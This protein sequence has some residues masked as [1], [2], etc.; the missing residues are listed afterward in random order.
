MKI[1]SSTFLKLL[2][3][4][5]KFPHYFIGSNADLPIV[6]GSILSHDHFQGGNYVFPMAKAPI[7]KEFTIPGFDG[8]AAG[9]INWPLSVIRLRSKEYS[10]LTGAATMILEKWRGYT[11]DKVGILSE[12]GGEKHNS[13]TPIARKNGEYFEIDLA[14]RNNRTAQDSPW[15]IFHPK[16]KLHHI[17]KENIG[18]IE[19]M[20]LAVLPSRLKKEIQLMQEYILEG[21]DFREN[22]EIKKHAFWFDGWK[23][24]YTF[25]DENVEDIL[26]QEIG[27]VFVEVLEDSGVF[28]RDVEG[29]KALSGSL[30]VL[31]KKNKYVNIDILEI[32]VI[33]RSMM[34]KLKIW[35]ENIP[36]NSPKS[37]LAE[38][39][40][41]EEYTM[42]DI[43]EKHP[44]V[45]DTAKDFTEDMSGNDT[46]VYRDEIMSGKAKETF[47]DEPY[48]IPYIVKGSKKCVIS[49]PGGAYLMKD[50]VN[51]GENV[52]AFLNEAGISC[53]V[54]WYR[55]YP[56]K[57]PVMF[58]DC[59][60]AI[61]YVRYHAADYGI[62]PE[63]INI[64]GFSA[65]GNLVGTTVEIFRDTPVEAEGYQPDEIDKVSAKVHSLGLIYPALTFEYSK[66]LLQC[67]E[68]RD[69]LRD[70]E[71]REKIAKHYTLKKSHSG[72]RRTTFLCNCIG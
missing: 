20:G 4:G 71:E 15:G 54:L 18:L 32:I 72:R 30:N 8:V 42:Q 16:E 45:F 31:Q 2:E 52:A 14:L 22:E 26:H 66:A 43:F 68:N 67:V 39:D 62:D 10:I 13:I 57:S 64:V 50:T 25:T 35:G 49:C 23:E 70:E 24:A 29:K 55:S 33:R 1:N 9:I 7:E 40:V 34:E 21:K 37:K 65:G 3:F 53:F 12:S 36:F 56:Y 46:M 11:D 51:E 19:V 6:G 58:R 28:K 63:D 38:M 17:K 69:L 47:E 41:H 60:R 59:Q 48:L 27:K 61:R 5:N 44:G